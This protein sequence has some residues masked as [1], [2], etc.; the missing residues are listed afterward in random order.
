[1]IDLKSKPI[2]WIIAGHHEEYVDY[3]RHIRSNHPEK[4]EQCDY[5]YVNDPNMLRGLQEIHG[6]F[7]GTWYLRPEATQIY[8]TI[9]L[10]HIRL[11]QD[12]SKLPAKAMHKARMVLEHHGKPIGARGASNE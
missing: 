8:E 10:S 6:S 9:W 7:I 2:Y 1:M 3:I 5:R 4:L 11:G 12:D